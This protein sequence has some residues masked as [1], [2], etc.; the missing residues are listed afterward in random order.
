MSEPLGLLAGRVFR[1][2][3]ECAGPDASVLP[4]SFI[5]HTPHPPDRGRVRPSPT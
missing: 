1:P 2:Q 3:A 5:K 4:H